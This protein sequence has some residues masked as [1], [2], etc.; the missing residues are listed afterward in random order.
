MTK[1]DI[2]WILANNVNYGNILS[3]IG[4]YV[5]H[6]TD[7]TVDFLGGKYVDYGF[8]LT[9]LRKDGFKTNAYSA[10]TLSFYSRLQ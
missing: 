8:F 2:M 1:M 3:I 7:N 4:Q 10:D 9:F 6:V 5:T